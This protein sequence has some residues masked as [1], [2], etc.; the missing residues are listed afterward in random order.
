V[1]EV[2]ALL[3]VGLTTAWRIVASGEVD[4]LRLGRRTL[5]TVESL[6]RYVGERVVA[7]RLGRPGRGA[8]EAEK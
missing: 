4:I 7:E 2:A 3:G 8:G 6:R 1:K 5:V